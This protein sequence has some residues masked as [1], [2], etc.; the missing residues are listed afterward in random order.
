MVG[1]PPISV[2]M[3][4]MVF[5]LWCSGL[6]AWC[7]PRVGEIDTTVRTSIK[8]RSLQQ[9]RRVF[10]GVFL[11]LEHENFQITDRETYP[12]GKIKR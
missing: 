12:Q 8:N 7:K 9:R 11:Q 1:K 6:R 10:A 2:R 3:D 4:E 5:N